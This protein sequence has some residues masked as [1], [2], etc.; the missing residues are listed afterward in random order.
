MSSCFLRS[1]LSSE[2]PGCLADD[3]NF[4]ASINY[5]QSIQLDGLRIFRVED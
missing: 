2:Y 5:M 1:W 4:I 3:G